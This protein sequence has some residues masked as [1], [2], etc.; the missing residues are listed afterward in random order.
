VQTDIPL[1]RLTTLR[2]PDL[3]PL[4]NIPDAT[5]VAVETLELPASAT[6]LDNV[7]RLRSAGGQEYL[8]VIE[9]Q[10]YPDP[11]VLWRLTGYLAWLGQ[12]YRDVTVIGTVIYLNPSADAGDTLRQTV[13][14][15]NLLV[16]QLPVVRLWELD[17]VAAAEQGSVGLAVLSPLMRGATADLV[18]Q[19]VVQV[20]EQAP[21]A[22]QA[23][24][25][26]ILGVFAEPLIESQAFVRLVGKEKLMSSDLITY[27]VDEK[28][29]E[30]ERK[31]TEEYQQKLEE[32]EQ[33]LTAMARTVQ[34]AVED[35]VILRFP[36]TPAFLVRNIRSVTDVERLA[37]LRRA[38]LRAPDQAYVEALLA[39]IP[40]AS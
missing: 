27:L 28:V 5:V 35:T 37:A 18:E 12:R 4:L 21:L 30:V 9:W 14:G 10:G 29:A 19:V 11:A 2:A 40:A 32:Y 17:A 25:L 20:L 3:L 36:N 1:K 26:S 33:K 24:L 38:V 15:R 7:L 31:V 39:A 8:H 6:R 13:D 16:W 22:Q 23:D 34:E